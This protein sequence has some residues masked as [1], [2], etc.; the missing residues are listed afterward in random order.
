MPCSIYARQ[1]GAVPSGR[2]VNERP[3][4]SS[5]VYIS[6][7]TM[8]VASPTVRTNSSE[9]SKTGVSIWPKPAPSASA[10]A[11]VTIS[12]RRA[13]SSGSRS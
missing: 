1:T 5:N 13:A 9:S 7:P 12:P 4:R 3:E 10:R 8:S 11:S 6:L 2:S